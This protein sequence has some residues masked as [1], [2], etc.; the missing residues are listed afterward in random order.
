MIATET[1]QVQAAPSVQAHAPA[2]GRTAP[3]PGQAVSNHLVFAILTTFFCCLPFGVVSIIFAAQVSG[4]L[5]QGDIEG[6]MNS[7]RLAKIWAWVS[8]GTG[9]VL[10]LFFTVFGIIAAV[11]ENM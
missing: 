11:A 3:L 6:A 8:F 10:F 1:A 2:T 7:S 5:A 4:K 9:L